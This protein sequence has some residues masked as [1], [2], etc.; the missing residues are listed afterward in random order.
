M[1]EKT[2]PYQHLDDHYDGDFE[3]RLVDEPTGGG[4]GLTGPQAN[5][6]LRALRPVVRV[7]QTLADVVKKTKAKG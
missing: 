7:G 2:D 1:A 4:K 5:A 3:L 6:F